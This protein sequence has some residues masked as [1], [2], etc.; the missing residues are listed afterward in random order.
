VFKLI[1]AT[2]TLR[3]IFQ[4]LDGINIVK[5]NIAGKTNKIVHGITEL[6]RRIL[7]TKGIDAL[8]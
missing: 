3:W 6:K 7:L 1:R 5:I 2:P 4:L 8:H